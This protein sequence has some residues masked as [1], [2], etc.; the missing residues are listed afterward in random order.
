[1]TSVNKW[2]QF[3]NGRANGTEIQLLECQHGHFWSPILNGSLLD[4]NIGSIYTQEQIVSLKLFCKQDENKNDVNNGKNLSRLLPVQEC[5][6]P[7]WLSVNSV[8]TR[9]MPHHLWLPKQRLD[10]F[11]EVS[12]LRKWVVKFLNCACLES[13]IPLFKITLLTFFW[14]IAWNIFCT[15]CGNTTLHTF[16]TVIMMRIANLWSVYYVPSTVSSMLSWIDPYGGSMKARYQ[17]CIP[18][19]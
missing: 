9:R 13:V 17:H 8:K 4:E 6:A 1:M 12:A 16:I 19:S 3:S 18:D 10:G 14:M 2:S 15:K 7:R 11:I 5:P